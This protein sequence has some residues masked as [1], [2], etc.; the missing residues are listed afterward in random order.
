[1][2]QD[3]I[4]TYLDAL[5]C[6]SGEVGRTFTELEQHLSQTIANIFVRTVQFT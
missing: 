4:P 2:S 3:P 6:H 5:L 1:M